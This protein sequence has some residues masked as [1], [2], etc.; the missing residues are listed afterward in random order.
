MTQIFFFGR[1]ADVAGCQTLPHIG[2]M[3]LCDVIEDL[4]QGNRDLGTV[5]RDPSTR[6]AI[7]LMLVP[8]SENPFVGASDELAFMPPVSGG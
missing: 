7:N 1:L 8:Y 3:T 5:L 6:A 4:A 2:A